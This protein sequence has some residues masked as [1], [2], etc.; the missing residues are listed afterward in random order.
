MFGTVVVSIIRILTACIIMH[1]TIIEDERDLQMPID[2]AREV[3]IPNIEMVNEETN[4]FQTF[5]AR[6]KKIKDK[7]AHFALH[8]ALIEHIWEEFS[9]S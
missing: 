5:L 2:D 7:D 4:E 9:N 1:N 6:F 3:L 8:N